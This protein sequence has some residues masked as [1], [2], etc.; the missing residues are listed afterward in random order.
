MNKHLMKGR[1]SALLAA[2]IVLAGVPASVQAATDDETDKAA[3]APESSRDARP[4][5]GSAPQAGNPPEAAPRR[6]PERQEYERRGLGPT[7]GLQ[8][9]REEGQP[10]RRAEPRHPEP[11]QH[12]ESRELMRRAHE[13]A[14]EGKPEDAEALRRKA[15]ALMEAGPRE[16]PGVPPR[17]SAAGEPHPNP[18]ARLRHL[19]QAIGHLREAGLPEP[20]ENLEGMARRLREEIQQQQVQQQQQERRNRQEAEEIGA[21][22][23]E[24]RELRETVKKLQ[25]KP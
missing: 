9:P 21:L 17:P 2:G 18:V 3:P 7:P 6:E 10:A 25:E 11:P 4:G 19:E 14:R 24:V 23:R 13:L 12:A 20:A 15:R 1:V 16:L 5:S 8:R 22:R